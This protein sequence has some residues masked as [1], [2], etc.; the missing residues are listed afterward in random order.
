MNK[1]ANLNDHVADIETEVVTARVC[2]EGT[3]RNIDHIFAH[4]STCLGELIQ[5]A[6][7]ANA[8]KVSIKIESEIVTKGINK[9]TKLIIQDN[10]TGIEDFSKLFTFSNS[11]WSEDTIKRENAFGCGF[12]SVLYFGLKT[13]VESNSRSILFD[14]E[15]ILT[16]LGAPVVVSDFTEPGTRITIHHPKIETVQD[17]LSI[18]SGYA[19]GCPMDITVSYQSNDSSDNGEATIVDK[20]M[21]PEATA[22]GSK[23]SL[24]HDKIEFEF[25]SIYHPKKVYNTTGFTTRTN[26][27]VYLQSLPIYLHD[28]SKDYTNDFR[29]FA[30]IT[31]GIPNLIDNKVIVHLNSDVKAR[32]PDRTHIHADWKEK[33]CVSLVK[34]TSEYSIT[35]LKDTCLS[36]VGKDLTVQ[37]RQF[38]NKNYEQICQHVE[39]DVINSIDYF[40]Q[41]HVKPLDSRPVCNCEFPLENYFS[42]DTI[43]DEVQLTHKK[44]SEGNTLLLL[45]DDQPTS[46]T[47]AYF[48]AQTDEREVFAINLSLPANHWLTD[49]VIDL[50]SIEV[51]FSSEETNREVYQDTDWSIAASFY[52]EVSINVY[53]H[54]SDA[55]TTSDEQNDE[56]EM[57]W[58]G[59]STRTPI[60]IGLRGEND[61]TMAVPE[62]TEP[63]ELD[64]MIYISDEW[65][66]NIEIYSQLD[67]DEW[68]AVRLSATPEEAVLKQITKA[69][70]GL[71]HNSMRERMDGLTFTIENGLP[72]IV[73]P[74]AA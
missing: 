14:K 53:K 38:L 1:P 24:T 8:T 23:L 21:R 28:F 71:S 70:N 15:A 26:L 39:T 11:G 37:D 29:H 59:S 73:Q 63:I 31:A 65:G 22:I 25:G 36:L 12:F 51:E 66:N 16:G 74:A 3:L 47:T 48:I 52:K 64:D 60:S 72:V 43:Q 68:L 10:G 18:I 20:V 27:L 35:K 2:S 45:V 32:H 56:K 42:D 49:Y 17:A 62:K 69:L 44:I 4:S 54:Q 61:F 5:N 50:T 57:L 7:R 41:L 55:L 30:A 33:V 13:Q 9:P 19:S 40:P 67:W 46:L 6:R 34:A 58:S